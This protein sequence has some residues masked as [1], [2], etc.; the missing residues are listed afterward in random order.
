MSIFISNRPLPSQ[1]FFFPSLFF[2]LHLRARK[3]AVHHRRRK[4]AKRSH[5]KMKRN[6]V[7]HLQ[8]SP[9]QSP[10]TTDTWKWTQ[11]ARQIQEVHK[12]AQTSECIKIGACFTLFFN[13]LIL[14][15][16]P[17]VSQLNFVFLVFCL[18]IGP[19]SQISSFTSHVP[20]K[21]IKTRLNLVCFLLFKGQMWRTLSLPS[22]FYGRGCTRR[23]KRPEDRYEN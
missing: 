3:M 20:F 12:L 16:A 9:V 21:L 23:L 5:S 6:K 10:H 22:M 4:S 14:F 18:F 17:F 13:I 2:Q 1:Y 11:N 19:T 15:L 7:W 8:T